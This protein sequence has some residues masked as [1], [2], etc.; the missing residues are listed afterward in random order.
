MALRPQI[1]VE[2]VKAEISLHVP[3]QIYST[4]YTRWLTCLSSNRWAG[5]TGKKS[6]SLPP[7]FD[8]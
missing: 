5:L 1:D 4:D 6:P 7:V 2:E 3:R 8:S